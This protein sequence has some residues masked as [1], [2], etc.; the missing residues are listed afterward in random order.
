VNP[1]VNAK[2]ERRVDTDDGAAGSATRYAQVSTGYL[3]VKTVGGRE[4]WALKKQNSAVS[5]EVRTRFR[6]DVTA[7]DRWV[8]GNT[9]LNVLAVFDPTSQ[10][11]ELVMICEEIK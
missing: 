1:R 5:H 11:K 10:R 8:F 3:D 9:V 4:F 6:E 7:S 2:L